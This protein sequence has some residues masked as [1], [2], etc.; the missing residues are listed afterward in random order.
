M[1]KVFM[2]VKIVEEQRDGLQPDMDNE[3]LLCF[4]GTHCWSESS[5]EII[6]IR[7]RRGRAEA[8]MRKLSPER[9][10]IPANPG[11]DDGLVE[12]YKSVTYEIRKFRVGD[13]LHIREEDED[14]D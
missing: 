11:V 14:E 5:E 10:L 13:I 2:I 4:R 12:Y 8:E 1:K 6:A 9:I 7:T 3:G